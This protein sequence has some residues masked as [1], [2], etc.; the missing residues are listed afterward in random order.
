MVKPGACVI[1]VGFRRIGPGQVRR[2]RGFR[3]GEESRRMDHAQSR[4]DRSD[5]RGRADAEP[6]RRSALS[7]WTRARELIQSEP[8]LLIRLSRNSP[9][10]TLSPCLTWNPEWTLRSWLRQEN[11]FATGGARI[12]RLE[13]R[14]SADLIG[15]RADVRDPE[16]F[17]SALADRVSGVGGPRL[18]RAEFVMLRSGGSVP[19]ARTA[20]VPRGIPGADD[21]ADGVH[22]LRLLLADDRCVPDRRRRLPGRDQAARSVCRPGLGMRAG[23]RLRADDLDFDR[24]RRR[25]DLQLPADPH[26]PAQVLGLPPGGGPDDRDEPARGEGIGDIAGADLPRVR[27]D[28]R[29]ADRV[30]AGKRASIFPRA[31]HGAIAAD[32]PRASTAWGSSRWRRFSCAPT[33]WAAEPTPGSRRSATACRFCASRAPSPASAR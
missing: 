29:V 27:H 1:D 11:G 21:G 24:E 3:G 30:R 10:L 19:R 32:S 22:H 14:R 15:P 9:N 26:A 13:K 4:R 25:R 20:S 28:A 18:G 12:A 17:P 2:R 8:V 7:A 6:D 33:A 5:D 31:V 23:D 16:N